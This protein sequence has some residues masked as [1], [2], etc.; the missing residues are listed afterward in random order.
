MK[1][2]EIIC[3]SILT[4]SSLPDCDYVI[5]PYRGCLH[6]CSYC[7][8][9]FMKKYTNHPEPW[10][11]YLDIKTNAAEIL[12]KELPRKKKGIILFSSVTDPYQPLE[13]K[14][15]LTKKCLEVLIPHQWPVSFLT[16]SNLILRD[17]KLLSQFKK[18]EIGLSLN[19]T[20]ENTR[21]IFEPHTTSIQK[22]L[23][24]LGELHNQGFRTYAFISPLLPELI[25]LESL[26]KKL[27]GKV[28]FIGFENLNPYFR[29]WP[30]IQKAIKEYFPGLLP[31]YQRYFSDDKY[32][33]SYWT[34]IQLE[35]KH[36]SKKSKIPAKIYFH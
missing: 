7:Y 12:Q 31:T 10:G 35:I 21:K 34:P 13:S 8:A 6:G 16:K 24:T 18:C 27:K 17:I 30:N 23:T 14:Y 5:N 2:K 19:T 33:S 28:N 20:S 36:L 32:R 22:R 9:S 3:K 25:D 4:K 11:S 1:I 26:F 15:Q 29:I